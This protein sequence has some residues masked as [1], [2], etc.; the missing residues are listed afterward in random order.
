MK[1]YVSASVLSADMLD[2]RNE[3]RKLEKSDIDMLHFDVMDGIFV[4]N[5]TFGLPV[6]QQVRSATDMTLDVHLMIADPL[7][8]AKRFAEFGADIISFHIESESDTLE[9]IKAIKECG[10][11]AAIAIKP[12]TPAE[13]VYEYL[14]Y[15][16]MVLVMTVEPGFGGQS[17]IPETADKIKKLRE[18]VNSIGI[19]TDIEVDGGINDK[20]ASIVLNAG[21][22]VLV[23]GS[24]LF[25][26]DD[27]KSAAAVLKEGKSC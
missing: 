25:T 6:L 14:P 20:T 15:L 22:N 24:Y 3:I 9:T 21:A 8:Y 4:N 1:N 7:K 16:D 18:K 12:A 26:S 5:I 10:V 13:A 17:F 19:E 2:F 11:K 27:M 23:S